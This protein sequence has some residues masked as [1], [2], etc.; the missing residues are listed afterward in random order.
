MICAMI[1]E[2]YG[3]LRFKST[4]MYLLS[5]ISERIQNDLICDALS[6]SEKSELKIFSKIDQ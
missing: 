1:I 5:I 4:Y 3:I 6:T 2:L